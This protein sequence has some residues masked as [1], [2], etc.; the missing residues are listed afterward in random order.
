MTEKPKSIDDL[1]IFKGSKTLSNGAH[2]QVITYYQCKICKVC[3][4]KEYRDD[5]YIFLHSKLYEGKRK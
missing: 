4:G 1:F 3:V 2:K 5:H